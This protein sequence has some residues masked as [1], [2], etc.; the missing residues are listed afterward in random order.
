MCAHLRAHRQTASVAFG[1]KV[2]PNPGFP[3]AGAVG[4]YELQAQPLFF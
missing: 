4:A 2:C 3:P 1:E